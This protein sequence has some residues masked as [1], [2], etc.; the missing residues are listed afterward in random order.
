MDLFQAMTV[1][2][3]VVEAGSMTAAAQQ[4][5][6]STTMV[7]NHLRALE[8]RLGV[9]LLNR[10]TRRQRLTEFG[11]AYY[12]RCLEVLGLVED[13]ERLAE[14]SQDTPSGTLRITA[15]LTFGTEKLAPALSE[16]TL[17]YPQVKLDVVLTNGRPDLLE[18]GLDVAFRLGAIEPSNLIAR[19]LI[20]Y[21]LTMC[22]SKSYLARRGTPEKPEDLQQHDCLSFAYPVGDDWQSVEKQWRLSGPEGEVMVAVRGPMLINSSAGLHQAARTGMGIV[23]LPDALVEQ[24]LLSGNLV[25]LMQDYRLPSRPM[26]LV[27]AQDRYR[28]PKLRRFVDFAMQMWAK[29]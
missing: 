26:H 20:D 24:D 27:Y 25:A 18:N 13:S 16:F 23:M 10:T 12:Q 14:Q 4:C 5:E 3:K 7:G 19:P 17:R 11:S 2:V 6:M 8:Q 28:L 21:T 15:P 22:A 29:H 1:Y 9:R